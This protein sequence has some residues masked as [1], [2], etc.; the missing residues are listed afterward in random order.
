[1]SLRRAADVK[2]ARGVRRGAGRQ[3]GYIGEVNET[4]ERLIALQDLRQLRQDVE[5]D[6]YADLGFEKPDTERIER[7]I[8]DLRSG[9]DPRFLTRFDRIATRFDRPLVPVRKGVC[10]GCFVRFAT[11]LESELHE[12]DSPL[13]CES[14]GRLLYRIP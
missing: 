8:Q 13:T 11:A 12:S 14:C 6:A 4:I 7:E 9:I 2:R 3:G 10:Y 5:Q 1:M